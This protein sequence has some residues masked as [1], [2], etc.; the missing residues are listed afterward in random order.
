MERLDYGSEVAV[1]PFQYR[2]EAENSGQAWYGV[3]LC[4]Q[5]FL[6]EAV[7][8]A[9]NSREVQRAPLLSNFQRRIAKN[10]SHLI[11]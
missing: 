7:S 2:K 10:T 9:Y 6:A 8:A 11:H 3:A 5:G 4:W 1:D